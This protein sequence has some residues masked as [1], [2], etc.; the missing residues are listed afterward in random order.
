M[1]KGS[2]QKA[3]GIWQVRTRVPDGNGERKQKSVS[4]GISVKGRKRDAEVKMREILDELERQYANPETCPEKIKFLDWIEKWIEFKSND[5]VSLGTIE[6]YRIYIDKHISPYF[7]PLDLSLAEVRPYHLQAFFD[8]E[9]K[10]GSSANS[11]KKY[12]VVIKGALDVALKN[13][14]IPY[15]PADRVDFP[16]TE[17]YKGTAYT[18]EQAK[19][20]LEVAK[21]T[22]IEPCVVLGLMYGLRRS[23][24]CGLLWKGIDFEKG[25]M[26]ITHTRKRVKTEVAEEKTKSNASKRTIPLIE[27]TVPFFQKMRF[28]QNK[29]AVMQGRVVSEDDYV[30]AWPD[31]RPYALKYVSDS[32]KRLLERNGL[33]PIRL[34]DLRH[35]I[36]SLLLEDGKSIKEVQEFLGHEK[37][38]TTLNIYAHASSEAMVKVSK[39]INELMLEKH[40]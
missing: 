29:N 30:C 5:R 8:E 6:S 27:D 17:Q 14:L 28:E 22:D 16:P 18:V 33:P 31:G 13:E 24:I 35:T 3:N 21:G 7:K 36:G 2:L 25:E 4:T 11:L 12:N 40:A 1:L 38:E 34:H 19:K 37:A 32:F 15:N 39:R 26:R 9:Y 10:N 20:L 23:E